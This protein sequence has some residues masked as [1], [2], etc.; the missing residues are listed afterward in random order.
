MT[1]GWT[2][3]F[4]AQCAVAIDNSNMRAEKDGT[5]LKFDGIDSWLIGEDGATSKFAEL[6]TV[7]SRSFGPLVP[8]NSPA[9]FFASPGSFEQGALN[10]SSKQNERDLLSSSTQPDGS[11]KPAGLLEQKQPET[12]TVAP[13][14]TTAA[15]TT[16]MPPTTTPGAIEGSTTATPTDAFGSTL[17]PPGLT[18]TVPP[19][20]AT[21][22]AT[23]EGMGMLSWTIVVLVVL[24]IIGL[25]MKGAGGGGGGGG[26]GGSG[27]G[28]G[29][30]AAG[31]GA[32]PSRGGGGYA[33]RRGG[34]G[35]V[36]QAE[37]PA[38]PLLEQQTQQPPSEPS[39]SRGGYAARRK[40]QEATD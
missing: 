31:G 7:N 16:T 5:R 23:A 11:V 30:R 35:T 29:G 15:P 2:I 39:P 18:E 19:T 14:T 38:A 28:G 8:H 1:L 13:A 12:T 9:A 24:V 3:L 25:V 21:E 27:G 33:S 22:G 34:G 10:D 32:A 37:A 36:A 40:Q 17:S 20:A 4:A 26:G 6:R